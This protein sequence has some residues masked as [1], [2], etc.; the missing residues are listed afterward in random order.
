MNEIVLS[1]E[2]Q[3]SGEE[4]AGI[5]I[6]VIEKPEENLLYKFLLGVDGTWETLRDYSKESSILWKPKKEAQY[7][8]MVQAKRVKT[9]KAFDYVTK[10]DYSVGLK[11]EKLIK[12]IYLEK[13]K[14]TLGEKL[15]LTVEA[16]KMPVVFRYWI[17]KN[18][19]YEIIKDYSAD[20]NLIWSVKDSGEQE[21]LVECKTL[22]SKDKC[23][24]SKKVKFKVE[25]L[26]KLEITD[27]KCLISD[28][29]VGN[30]LV[31]Q[32]EAV[33]DD[34]RMIL[35][36]FI[37]IND[38]GIATCIQDYSTKRMVN[39]VE[40]ISGEYKL[41]CL[42]KDMY[43]QKE[44]DDRAI[45]N[46]AIKEYKDIVINSF[47]TDL[48]SPQICSTIVTLKAI[49]NGGKELQYKFKIDGNL[50][51]DSGYTRNNTYTWNCEKAGEYKL[52]VYVKDSAYI[53]DFEAV[54][55][56]NF[57]VEELCLDP[58]VINNVLLD[59]G[60]KILKGEV[61]NIRAVASGGTDLR[62]R[63]I[64]KKDGK[65]IYSINY[66]TCN[67]V[68]FSQNEKGTYEVEVR[69]KDK[70]SNRLYDSHTIIYIEVFNYIPALI[71]QILIP[72]KEHYLV[73]D[74]IS[75]SV[76]AQNTKKTLFKYVLSIN[77]HKVEETNFDKYSKYDLRPK[78]SGAYTLEVFA[79]NEDSEAEFDSKKD[80]RFNISE[81]L[82][83]TNTQI[84]FDKNNLY[85]NKAITFTADS[86]GGK[87]VL[88]QF[89]LMEKGDWILAQDLS[90]NNNYTFIPFAAGNY[91]I[92]ALC[93]SSYKKCVY[94]DYS[95]QEFNV[96]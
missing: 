21:I 44:Y 36:K 55:S 45:L 26:K 88:Y 4:I 38:E 32:V 54:S 67:W 68:D 61:L 62:Y 89:Y 40:N 22:D 49:V 94:E 17:N 58:I 64:E 18:G 81:A 19:S 42:A 82:P 35:Y 28:L 13:E 11:A 34:Q 29:Y 37:K 65:E 85:V 7:T 8:I 53:G 56:M 52:E 90:R 79:K 73:G 71:E 75:C 60:N 16:N 24:D 39:F 6:K 3:N 20:N 50:S 93:K 48:N 1:F 63:F 69:V 14:L 30:E 57:K 10:V 25:Q 96:G 92:L 86:E 78:C 80:V 46:Y 41:L 27:F 15:N 70:Y 77:G 83:I 74:L 9:T 43:S 95:L 23:D 2:A 51:E 31:F 76:I 12:D 84:K 72:I 66:G 91:K 47:T 33:Q 59:K 5:N 87:E